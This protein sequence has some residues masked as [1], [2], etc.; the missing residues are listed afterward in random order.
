MLRTVVIYSY[1]NRVQ[2]RDTIAPLAEAGKTCGISGIL[3]PNTRGFVFVFFVF[4]LAMPR[5]NFFCAKKSPTQDNPNHKR[6]FHNI[7]PLRGISRVF[8]STGGQNR[9]SLARACPPVG[10]SMAASVRYSSMLPRAPTTL[11]I[12]KNPTALI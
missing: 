1:L 8:F 7:S 5:V 2:M 10:S 9:V 3:S 6:R 12:T 4:R 11:R